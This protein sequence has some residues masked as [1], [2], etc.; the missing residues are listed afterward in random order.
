MR[1]PQAPY[2]HTHLGAP[3]IGAYQGEAEDMSSY[4]DSEA[5]DSTQ[6]L[7]DLEE[8]QTSKSL[9]K[10]F[11]DKISLLH[12]V[13]PY[14]VDTVSKDVN[15]QTEADKIFDRSSSDEPTLV[16][17]ESGAVKG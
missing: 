3:H 16:L 8:D 5:G 6:A 4:A 1:N 2:H 17:L 13:A 15:I 9:R 7:E 14:L 10:S 11:A 12:S